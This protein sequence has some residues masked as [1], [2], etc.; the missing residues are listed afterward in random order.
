[1]LNIALIAYDIGEHVHVPG[2]IFY[3]SDFSGANC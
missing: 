2:R 3:L 1:M